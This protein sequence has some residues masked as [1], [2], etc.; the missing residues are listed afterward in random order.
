MYLVFL[1]V[2]FAL[3]FSENDDATERVTLDN[4]DGDDDDTD[5]ATGSR[6]P[7]SSVSAGLAAA[8]GAA[9]LLAGWGL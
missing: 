5:A 3:H 2:F 8:A 4:E 1:D 9:V 7:R 6:P